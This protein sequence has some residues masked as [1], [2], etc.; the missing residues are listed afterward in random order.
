MER[1]LYVK[2]AMGTLAVTTFLFV[3]P[4]IAQTQTGQSQPSQ[5]QSNQT[6][7]GDDRDTT[8]A[9]LASFDQFLDRHREIAEQVRKN[10]SLVNN[11]Q[12]V[13][14]HPAL[15]TYLQQHPNVS[16]EVKE[17][18][19]AFMRQENRYDRREDARADRDRDMNRPDADRNVNR[20]NPDNRDARDNDRDRDMNRPDA[21]RNVNRQNPDN[22]QDARDND[23]DR[24]NDRREADN[25]QTST[26]TSTNTSA[27]TSARTSTGA[28]ANTSSNTNANQ[29]G[30]DADRQDADNRRDADDRRSDQPSR[31]QL[32]RFDQFMD[33]HREISEQVKKDPD[34][35]RNQQYIQ[36]HPALQ[37]FLQ[38]NQDIR[39]QASLHPNNFMQREDRYDMREDARNG[40]VDRRDRN[41]QELAS[42]DRFLDG[43]RED[44]EQLR[45]NPSLVNNQQFVQSHPALQ[46]YLQDH[47]AVREQL[48]QNPNAFMQR[49]DRYDAREDAR[50]GDLDRRDRDRDRDMDNRRDDRQEGRNATSDRPELASFDRFLDSHREVSEQLRRDPSLVNNKQFV[51]NHPALQTYLQQNPNVH[52]AITQ[53][54]NAF[55]RQENQYDRRED[56]NR[57]HSME[58][59]NFREFL[60]NHSN[61][62]QDLSRD[63]RKANDANYQ[64]THP[65]FRSYLSAHPAVQ[66]AL[67]Q[68]P[69]N[70]MKSVQQPA[71]TP[72]TGT[73]GTTKPST[74]TTPETK[75]PTKP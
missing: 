10:P 21:D 27:S 17:N 53:D 72:T 14:S 1:K 35:L 59:A 67:N 25:R 57:G 34:L 66:T 18:P 69:E 6:Q 48:T 63:P 12:F 73:T 44:A 51:Q 38:Q 11:P 68:N 32:A 58:A 39:Q 46:S 42:F 71:T 55:M 30:T 37:S 33:R 26:S 60:G 61:I 70:F 54:P 52:Q 49:E 29:S 74:T 64:N 47:P 43:H 45:R 65:E 24:D 36:A 75:P 9:E 2:Q 13:Q 8:R 31:G 28:S 56:M 23:R 16:A 7:R 3:A 15:Q 22:R 41:R 50:N 5:T 19:N 40:D 4:G 62:S 20:Q